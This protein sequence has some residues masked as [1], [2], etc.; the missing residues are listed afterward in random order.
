VVVLAGKQRLGFEFA[1]VSIGVR[2]FL[3]EVLQQFL[4]LFR[5]GF[6]FGEFD[7][8]L[9]VADE[10]LQFLIGGELIFDL[11]AVAENALRFF[12]IAPEIGIGGALFEGFQ[13][14]AIL[15]GVKESSARE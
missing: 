15:G 6:A 9:D 7:V 10:R 14:R 5:V 3:A 12:L 8:R 13:A 2:E 1:D 11:L 4:F